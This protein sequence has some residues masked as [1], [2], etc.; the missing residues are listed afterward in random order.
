MRI[1][2]DA[3]H[4]TQRRVLALVAWFQRGARADHGDAQIGLVFA[5]EVYRGEAV[6]VSIEDA[7]IWFVPS[8]WLAWLTWLGCHFQV[9]VKRPALA[10]DACYVHIPDGL[11]R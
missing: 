10:K 4:L 7:V 6:F 9:K 11:W 1:T 5:G 3:V 2:D 8:F